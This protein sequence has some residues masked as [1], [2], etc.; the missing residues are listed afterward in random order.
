M[1]RKFVMHKKIITTTFL[2]CLCFQLFA[3]AFASNSGYVN[4]A[5]RKY[6]RGNYSG[7]MQDLEYYTKIPPSNPTAFYY[8]AMSYARAGKKNSAIDSYKKVMALSPNRVLYNYASKGKRCLEDASKCDYVDASKPTELDNVINSSNTL[9]PNVRNQVEQQ[10]LNA[11]KQQINST[12]TVT[13]KQLNKVNPNYRTMIDA[14]EKIAMA[15][16]S[17]EVGTVLTSSEPVLPKKNVVKSTNNVPSNEDVAKAL[18]VL[19]RAGYGKLLQPEV[20]N[21][22]SIGVGRPQTNNAAEIQ[23]QSAE[24]AQMMQMSALMGSNSN[25]NNNNNNNMMNMLPLMLMQNQNGQGGMSKQAVEALMMNSL[26]PNTDFSSSD[27]NK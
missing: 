26:M 18:D 11:L 20:N 25:N 15:G 6:K 21:S 4:N 17:T 13:N 12:G 9:S 8:L 22:A 27:S 19:K 14:I 1:I 3:A 24:M 23:K 7:C 10:R 16:G 2:I 5:I